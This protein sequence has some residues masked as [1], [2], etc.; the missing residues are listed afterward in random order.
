MISNITAIASVD[1]Q[2]V[3]EALEKES[4][5]PVKAW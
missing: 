4:L 5:Q 1:A 3:E 2:R